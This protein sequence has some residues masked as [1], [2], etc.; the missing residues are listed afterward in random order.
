MADIFTKTLTFND[1]LTTT[2]T[3]LR[4]KS[5]EIYLEQR[6]FV[7]ILQPKRIFLCDKEKIYLG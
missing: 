2:D 1:I 5:A 7:L 6:N 4:E 3:T